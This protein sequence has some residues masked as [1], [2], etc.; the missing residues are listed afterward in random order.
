[1]RVLA[2]G[3]AARDR[4]AIVAIL[5]AGG[6]TYMATRNVI[7]V[8]LLW[9]SVL[10]W[11]IWVGGTVYQMLVIVPMWSGSLPES[12]H[13]FL[14]ATNFTHYVLRFF[15][16]RWIPLRYLS[17][18]ALVAC[19]WNLPTHRRLFL[20]ATIMMVLGLVF[21][22]AY[23]YPINHVVFDQAGAGLGAEEVRRLA[24]RWIIADRVRFV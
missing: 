18:L 22:L 11:S 17:L 5:R 12:L 10:S 2:G 13:T 14:N 7:T 16:P 6:C 19:G 15:G 24:H 1:M 8:V 21:T 23:I 9:I 3:R 4:R 20:S